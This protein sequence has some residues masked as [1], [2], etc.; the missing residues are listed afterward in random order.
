MK[1]I[2]IISV[3]LFTFVFLCCLP[4]VVLCITSCANAWI[5]PNIFPQSY[6]IENFQYVMYD[7]EIVKAIITSIIVGVLCGVICILVGLPTARA[8]ALYNFR[9]KGII[10][11]LVLLPLIV[12]SL[13]IVSISHINMMQMKIAGT[14]VGVSIIHSIFAL[15]YSIRIIYDNLIKIGKKYEEQALNLGASRVNVFFTVTIP[16]ILPA[17]FLAFFLCFTISMSQ[18]ITTLIIGGGKI[19]TISTLLVPYIQYGEYEIA[20]V[21][22]LM[23]VIISFVGYFFIIKIQ[24]SIVR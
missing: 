17:S 18:Y 20:S 9:G 21:Y 7:K 1:D 15:P 4:I 19:I 5:Y 12:P 16:L 22:S 10:S 14:L 3:I 2:S 8:L 23:L 24:R 11:L 6:S 13:T